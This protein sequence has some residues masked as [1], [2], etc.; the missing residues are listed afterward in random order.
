[1]TLASTS[2]LALTGIQSFN[3]FYV[4]VIHTRLQIMW[5]K[6][7]YFSSLQFPHLCQ[8]SALVDKRMFANL[9]HWRS[10]R[11][12]CQL[13]PLFL[14]TWDCHLKGSTILTKY[15]WLPLTV[16]RFSVPKKAEQHSERL[17]EATGNLEDRDVLVPIAFWGSSVRR[18]PKEWSVSL[19]GK[20][21]DRRMEGKE[22]RKLTL[23]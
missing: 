21:M 17:K 18:W 3:C 11:L 14:L 22:R 15:I 7:N 2:I 1:M 23:F 16:V 20:H 9:V 6:N 10:S 4:S 12:C 19:Q 8:C 5:G 13:L